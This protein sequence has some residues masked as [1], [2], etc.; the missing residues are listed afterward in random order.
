MWAVPRAVFVV[1]FAWWEPFKSVEAPVVAHAVAPPGMMFA[2][3][4]SESE[5]TEGERLLA[6]DCDWWNGTITY[7]TAF[8]NHFT[9]ARLPHAIVEQSLERA[10]RCATHYE[11]ECVLS[12]EIGLSRFATCARKGG[13]NDGGGNGT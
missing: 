2:P 4:V 5:A 9:I 1:V 8:C 13:N 3:W 10:I 12:F 7:E 6:P 11:T